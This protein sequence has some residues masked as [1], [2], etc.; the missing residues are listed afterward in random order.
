MPHDAAGYH[1]EFSDLNDIALED[2]DFSMPDIED[3]GVN[4]NDQAPTDPATVDAQVTNFGFDDLEMQMPIA[5]MA[6]LSASESTSQHGN[7]Q[8]FMTPM[9]EM[10]EPQSGYQNIDSHVS[11]APM[12]ETLTLGENHER[13][14]TH[15]PYHT[16]ASTTQ[17]TLPAHA[18]VD[19][20]TGIPPV[21]PNGCTEASR[22][23]WDRQGWWYHGKH[24]RCPLPIAHRHD[25]NGQVSFTGMGD[26]LKMVHEI[27][28]V[29]RRGH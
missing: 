10:P 8:L 16:F 20:K 25:T 9:N 6:G 5:A 3:T 27:M 13:R 1:T 11:V 18:V 19:N 7:S 17:I 21:A 26:V 23:G 12:A 4:T 24:D 28:G 22:S 15:L 2:F 29:A 14:E